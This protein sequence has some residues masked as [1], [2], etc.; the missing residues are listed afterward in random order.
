M[1]G[2]VRESARERQEQI[3]VLCVYVLESVEA[4]A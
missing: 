4:R 3:N 1:R 2:R